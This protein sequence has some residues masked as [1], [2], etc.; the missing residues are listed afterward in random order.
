[1]SKNKLKLLLF[2]PNLIFNSDAKTNKKN[3]KSNTVSSK[4]NSI[5]KQ[6]KEIIDFSSIPEDLIIS[7]NTNF[8][9]LKEE[10]VEN[11]AYFI[12]IIEDALK[13]SSYFT[14]IEK[15]YEE[16]K[17]TNPLENYFLLIRLIKNVLI[18]DSKEVLGQ[19]YKI[20]LLEEDIKFMLEI[21]ILENLSEEERH[22][23]KNFQKE[24]QSKDFILTNTFIANWNNFLKKIPNKSKRSISLES[25]YL[26]GIY[27]GF[28][29]FPKEILAIKNFLKKYHM[30]VAIEERFNN[31]YSITIINNIEKSP[32][33]TYENFIENLQKV[34]LLKII[35]DAIYNKSKFTYTIKGKNP[36][37]ILDLM[38]EKLLFEK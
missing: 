17:T 18:E 3:I 20:A 33:L 30:W 35:K 11:V 16:K 14:I 34:L 22:F 19:K 13:K 24:Q 31:S 10:E 5:N 37:E 21:L 4:T 6:K 15:I 23:V 12:L 29:D 1:M 28:I 26:R 25:L 32:P 7:V 2:L 9:K 36:I 8:P 38:F 27:V